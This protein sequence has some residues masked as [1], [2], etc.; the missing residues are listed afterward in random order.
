MARV[1]S[2][3][4]GPYLDPPTRDRGVR[5]RSATGASVVSLRSSGRRGLLSS[6]GPNGVILRYATS[7]R[8]VLWLGTRVKSAVG[9][10]WR[11]TGK[12]WAS[13]RRG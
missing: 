2:T 4:A 12:L 11:L 3:V 5:A 7:T 9:M 10:S 1:P 6:N 8:S 13:W